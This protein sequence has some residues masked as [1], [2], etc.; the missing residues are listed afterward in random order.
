MK[1]DDDEAKASFENLPFEV[2]IKGGLSNF[3]SNEATKFDIQ[4]F[5]NYALRHCDEV[6]RF[7]ID[8]ER[9]F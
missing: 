4:I 5:G 8:F 3:Q 2:S 6:I 1:L 9:K 7:D